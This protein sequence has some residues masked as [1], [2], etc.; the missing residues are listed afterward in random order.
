[1]SGSMGGPSGGDRPMVNRSGCSGNPLSDHPEFPPRHGRQARWPLGVAPERPPDPVGSLDTNTGV[2]ALGGSLVHRRP[3][4]LE[5][6]VEAGK[7]PPV[8]AYGP[9]V[10]IVRVIGNLIDPGHGRYQPCERNT[11][12]AWTCDGDR[13]VFVTS[14]G[15][16]APQTSV[17]RRTTGCEGCVC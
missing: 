16:D 6:A 10:A 13:T 1:M 5:A 2:P 12:T 3:K 9:G 14:P 15:K 4:R 8:D 7:H 17:P 11:E